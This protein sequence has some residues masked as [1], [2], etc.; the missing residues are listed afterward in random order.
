MQ[1]ISE[2]TFMGVKLDL[3]TY[4]KMFQTMES[5]QNVLGKN[6]DT[7]TYVAYLLG[8]DHSDDVFAYST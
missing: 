5:A 7:L 6:E 3:N 1:L 2:I 8:N 4:V